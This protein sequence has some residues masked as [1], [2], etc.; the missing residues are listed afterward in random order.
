MERTGDLDVRART[1]VAKLSPPQVGEVMAN[2]TTRWPRGEHTP[3]KHLV[4]QGYL[5]A[6]YPILG[7]T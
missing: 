5:K 3:G 4:L 6:W 1:E 2:E 7:M